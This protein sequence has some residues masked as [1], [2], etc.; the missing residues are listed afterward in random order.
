MSNLAHGFGFLLVYVGFLRIIFFSGT[1]S[2]AARPTK[3]ASTTSLSFPIGRRVDHTR[4]PE[5]WSQWAAR[6]K[7]GLEFKY[8]DVTSVGKRAT[9]TLR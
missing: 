4:T 3:D 5:E 8:R 1:L 7:T 6:Q 9:S 2:V